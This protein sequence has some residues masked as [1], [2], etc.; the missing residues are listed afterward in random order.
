MNQDKGGK[1]LEEIVKSLS[2]AAGEYQ[3]LKEKL[4][5]ILNEDEKIGE[6]VAEIG[7]C[8]LQIAQIMNRM[9]ELYLELAKRFEELGEEKLAK[10]FRTLALVADRAVSF[11]LGEDIEREK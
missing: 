1:I 10:I 9:Q 5:K 8:S 11:T 7:K 6:I 4:G 3:V 2:T